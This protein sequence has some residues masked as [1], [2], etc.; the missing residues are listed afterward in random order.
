MADEFN[1]NDDQVRR[2]EEL[3]NIFGE[4]RNA[5]REA[6]TSLRNLGET[7]ADYGGIYSSVANSASKVADIQREVARSEAGTKKVLEEKGK[8]QDKSRRL[9][10]QINSLYERAANATGEVRENLL[11]Q[12]R[13][14]ANARDVAEEL[15]VIYSEIA[16]QAAELDKSTVFFRGMKDFVGSIPG[17]KALSG[18][19]EDA[20][21]A[22]RK[23]LVNAGS[24]KEAF[25]AGGKSLIQGFSKALGPAVLLGAAVK[26]IIDLFVSAQKN[27]VEIARNLGISRSSA[28]NL[29]KEFASIAGSSSNLLMNTESLIAAQKSL[30]EIQ[31][32]STRQTASTLENQVFLTKN[33]KL[34]GEEAGNLNTMMTAFGGNAMQAT[35]AILQQNSEYAKQTGLLM[36]A[37]E[38]LSKIASVGADIAGYFAFNTK[39]IAAGIRETRRFGIS[40]QQ[41]SQIASSLL[42][43]EQSISAELDAELLTG[44]DF[45]FELARSKALQGDIA[46]ASREVLSQ[47]QNLTEEQRKSPLIME[48][49]AK[50]TGLSAAEINKAFMLQSNL[51]MKTAEYDELLARAGKT[52]SAVLVEQL[53]LQ[54]ASR[55]EIEKTLTA[56]EAFAAALAKAKDQFAGLVNSGVLDSLVDVLSSFVS[57]MRSYGFG[58]ASSTQRFEESLGKSS[59]SA[60]QQARL[61]SISEERYSLFDSYGE[62]SSADLVEALAAGNVDLTTLSLGK[63]SS[64]QDIATTKSG[65][66]FELTKETVSVLKELLAETKGGKSI[67]LNGQ[68]VG[69]TNN[70]AGGLYT[71]NAR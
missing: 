16:E 42:D 39:E 28:E 38:L 12:S 47:I 40:L 4:I 58:R 9:T 61:K 7:A 69:E 32:F 6:N 70:Q 36:P 37:Q 71:Y 19:F 50:A 45:N 22:A 67:V 3:K 24:S 20:A 51:N 29:R 21:A 13:N 64:N 26:F 15:T 10:A 63:S 52:G 65:Q 62:N 8:L 34:A 17:L 41:A 31:G 5:T 35:D 1:L 30:I 55:Q 57:N 59:L 56:Q 23:T 54:G 18:P 43:F 14:L 68:K 27:T 46:G 66:T 60:A 33:L 49:V 11:N 2:A 25:A 53:G 44:R 48:S